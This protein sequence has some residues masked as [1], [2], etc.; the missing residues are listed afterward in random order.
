VLVRCCRTFSPE[1][2]TFPRIIFSIIFSLTSRKHASSWKVSKKGQLPP[3]SST[4]F[5][6]THLPFQMALNERNLSDSM[7]TGI[8][9]GHM[10]MRTKV[11]WA[12]CISLLWNSTNPLIFS[13]LRW[14]RKFYVKSILDLVFQKDP[15]IWIFWKIKMKSLISLICLEVCFARN[16]HIFSFLN[17]FF[18]ITG[19]W[20]PEFRRDVSKEFEI[21]LDN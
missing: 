5:C 12:F 9:G 7:I 13:F 2:M 8:Y 21:L 18:L 1:R 6:L 3:L 19:D 4:C 15:S 16:L 10:L 14:K 11:Y 17:F 20:E